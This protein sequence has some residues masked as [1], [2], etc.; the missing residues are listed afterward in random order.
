MSVIESVCV[1]VSDLSSDTWVN[2]PLHLELQIDISCDHRSSRDGM[3]ATT[4][5]EE[6]TRVAVCGL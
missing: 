3:H 6:Q 4:H 5:P 1:C 2:S